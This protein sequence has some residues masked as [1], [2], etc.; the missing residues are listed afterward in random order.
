MMRPRSSDRTAGYADQLARLGA[1]I[2]ARRRGLR[3]TQ[4]RLSDE[5]GVVQSVISRVEKGA[6]GRRGCHISTLVAVVDALG[7]ELVLSELRAQ[8]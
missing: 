1:D 6:P 4:R 2:R 5:A 7:C 3:W 8:G